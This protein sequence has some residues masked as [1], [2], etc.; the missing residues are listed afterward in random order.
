M[1]YMLLKDGN[2]RYYE[3][4][5]NYASVLCELKEHDGIGYYWEY[6]YHNWG[7]LRPNSVNADN[8]PRSGVPPQIL[9]A[10]MLE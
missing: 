1:E 2:V 3:K 7:C 8:V 9:L 4:D 5:L 6:Q 10:A